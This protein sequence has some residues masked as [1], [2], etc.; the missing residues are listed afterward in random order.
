MSQSTLVWG[1]STVLRAV[2]SVWPSLSIPERGLVRTVPEHQSDAD[3]VSDAPVR[4]AKALLVGTERMSAQAVALAKERLVLA[5]RGAGVALVERTDSGLALTSP[6]H[7][8]RWAALG[9]RQCRK[10]GRFLKA[11]KGLREHMNFTHGVP[12]D[13]AVALA[14]GE[15]A[16]GPLGSAAA[17]GLSK[18]GNAAAAASPQ[19]STDP[20]GG[21]APA[22]SDAGAADAW[23]AAARSGDTTRM[24]ELLAAGHSPV[25]VQD[26]HGCSCLSWAAG[27]G[28]EDAV[29]LLLA[30]GVDAAA[31]Q[32]AGQLAG[33]TP[34]H[35]AAR[36]GA[37]GVV[38]LL[39]REAG[40]PPNPAAA[41][42]TTP[43]HLACWQ[44]HVAVCEALLHAEPAGLWSVNATDCGVWHWA[45][46]G[47]ALPVLELLLQRRGSWPLLRARNS[48]GHAPLHKAA[49]RGSFSVCRWLVRAMRERQ[50]PTG[51]PG[52]EAA[53]AAALLA[54]LQPG[55]DGLSPSE[56]AALAGGPE[57][58][59]A[60]APGAA[61]LPADRAAER[62]ALAAYLRD[63][64]AEAGV[65]GLAA[66]QLGVQPGAA[67][68]GDVKPEGGGGGGPSGDLRRI[69]APPR[70]APP[71]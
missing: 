44:G 55:D 35:F 37:L 47:G 18:P 71:P 6:E 41:D 67:S 53:A 3:L 43:L 38:L 27:S 13:E 24:G 9:K 28:R 1:T 10:C 49:Q 19:L 54:S 36:N 70:V 68:V 22:L 2:G 34:L 23:L 63:L 60:P 5:L 61:G 12:W 50:Q 8:A 15:E 7:T 64:E 30:A 59:S 4:V 11:P 32:A 40:V 21:D 57:L 17:G 31:G 65:R 29:R 66:Q 26:R 48:N 25:R 39:L 20:G 42:G 56:L 62:A 51:A 69:V 45:A 14:G 58:A 16:K 46:Q 33:R 52:E